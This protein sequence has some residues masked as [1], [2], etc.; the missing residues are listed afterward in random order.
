MADK[1]DFSF[2]KD[3]PQTPPSATE[4]SAEI[5]AKPA[6]SRALL[7]GLLLVVLGAAAYFYAMEMMA[8]EEV[9]VPAAVTKQLI[10]PPPPA[11]A[12][13]AAA[14]AKQEPAT[15]DK[16]AVPTPGAAP[17]PTPASA[18]ETTPAA[19]ELPKLAEKGVLK[20]VPIEP[21]PVA[22]EA[23]SPA[24]QAVAEAT[25]GSPTATVDTPSA[26]SGPEPGPKAGSKVSAAGSQP[27]RGAYTLLAGAYISPE[28]LKSATSKVKKLGYQPRTL[29]DAKLVEMTRVRIGA[30]APGEAQSKLAEVKKIAPDAFTLPEGDQVVV[31]AA[32]H[33]D[34]AAHSAFADSLRKAGVAFEEEK[35]MRKMPM[36][37]LFF[38][39]FPDRDAAEKAAEKARKAGL[40][41]IVF[42]RP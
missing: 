13:D 33:F 21:P 25:A 8:P 19:Q 10:T 20:E 30:Y 12:G 9:A 16:P 35:V 5:K 38:G 41:I 22:T 7:L 23:V 2:D 37:E 18:T 26:P 1:D 17:T 39:E 11:P 28:M 3:A 32:S 27:S 42:K 14:S 36:T 6:P 15:A 4:P 31:Y 40:E 29:R 34:P 24:A